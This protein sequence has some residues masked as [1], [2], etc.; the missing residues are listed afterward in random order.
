MKIE[1]DKVYLTR[2]GERVRVVCVDGNAASF[3]IVGMESDG[4]VWLY[5]AK[6]EFD[7]D[8]ESHLDLISEYVEPPKPREVWVQM[9]G[10]R[11]ACA[12][13]EE[14]IGRLKQNN[15]EAFAALVKF[16]EVIE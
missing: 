6:G 16:R 14:E 4:N 3:P 11:A 13:S 10:R 8:E 12:W 1:R 5:T 2:G 9:N 7:R 15:P